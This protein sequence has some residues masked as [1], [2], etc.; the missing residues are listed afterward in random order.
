MNKKIPV[1]CFLPCCGSKVATGEIIQGKLK[2]TF[3]SINL[4]QTLNNARNSHHF[5]IDKKSKLTSGFRLYT[6]SPYQAI[7]NQE[8]VE[9]SIFNNTLR[10]Y[11]ISAGYGVL[12]AREP[13]YHY[14][15]VMSGSIAKY[16]REAGLVS[17]IS[18]IIKEQSPSKV[19]G[20]FA[21]VREW[22]TPSSKYRYFFTEAVKQALN[23]SVSINSAGCFYRKD[24]FGTKAILNAL[25]RT[26][27]DVYKKDYSSKY[28]KNI[29]QNDRKDGNVII[30]FDR[31]K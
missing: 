28:I 31:L 14:D 2:G 19:Y 9:Q 12:D 6:G 1:L 16:W 22:S 18:E 26:F 8:S 20:F 4:H 24:G 17:V 10:I 3:W 7:E 29:E 21:G 5:N 13:I 25:G 27:N 11:I 30:G 23:E 15:E